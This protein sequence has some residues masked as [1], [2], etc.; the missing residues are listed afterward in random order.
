[1]APHYCSCNKVGAFYFGGDT[2]LTD[3]DIINITLEGK[4]SKKAEMLVDLL[5]EDNSFLYEIARHFQDEHRYTIALLHDILNVV[6]IE[7]LATMGFREP[8]LKSID[9]LKNKKDGNCCCQMI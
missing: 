8:Y 9:I 3:K 5:Y 1:M 2:I 4:Q 6:T 7:E